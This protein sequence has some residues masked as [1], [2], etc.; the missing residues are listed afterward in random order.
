[1]VEV[2]S[3]K[4]L[5]DNI[6]YIITDKEYCT[7]P[8]SKVEDLFTFPVMFRKTD[9]YLSGGYVKLEVIHEIPE[10]NKEIFQELHPEYYI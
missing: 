1:M 10:F 5:E 6:V 4:N 3:L 7:P 8:K 2:W 9:L